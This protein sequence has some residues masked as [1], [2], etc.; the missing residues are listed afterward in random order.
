MNDLKARIKNTRSAQKG[1]TLI[2][3]IVVLALMAILLSI[4]IFG[5]L[6]W[7]DWV[8]FQQEDTA[9]EDIFYAAQNQL[10]E[11]DSSGAMKRKVMDVLWDSEG[12]NYIDDYILA[13][14]T[15]E[16]HLTK[17]FEGFKKTSGEIYSWDSIWIDGNRAR[18]KRTVIHL[19]VQE[20]KYDEYLKLSTSTTED[21]P[22]VADIDTAGILLFDLIAPYISDKSVLNGA[23]SLEFSPE[24]GQV[25]AVCYSDRTGK[26]AY[27]DTT[28]SA[29]NIK[30][31]TLQEREKYMIGYYGVDTLTN[32]I[33]GRATE[34]DEYRLEIENSTALTLILH[35]KEG[36]TQT[37][38][39]ANLTFSIS[40]A[41][42][43]KDAAGYR[44]VMKFTFNSDSI[45]NSAVS[46]QTAAESPVT[47][48]TVEL[49]DGLYLNKGPQKF[50]IPMW[51]D[52]GNIYIALDAADVQAQSLQHAEMFDILGSNENDVAAAKAAFANTYSFYRFGLL[53]TRFI[54]AK[55]T[56][57]MGGREGEGEA[58][59]KVEAGETFEKYSNSG[60]YSGEAVTFANWDEG[61]SDDTFGIRNGRHF[62]NI[63]FE[64]DYSDAF[65]ASGKYTEERNRIFAL[66][67]D[68]DWKDFVEGSNGNCFLDSLETTG[69]TT[70]SYGINL[71]LLQGDERQEL[72]YYDESDEKDKYPRDTAHLPFP[73][74]RILSYGNQFVGDMT[75]IDEEGKRVS[76]IPSIENID[77]TLAANCIY[78]VYGKDIQSK[79]KDHNHADISAQGKAGLLPL[80]LFA[81]SYGTLRDIELDQVTVSGIATYQINK[82]TTFLFTSKVG[83]FV[84][85]N[86][87]TIA[88]LLI[89]VK[90][91]IVSSGSNAPKVKESR[92]RGRADVGGIVGH[93]YYMVDELDS[94]GNSV[95][96]DSKQVISGCE[97]NA[98][99]TGIGY[100]G[101]IIG[102]I[103][104]SGTISGKAAFDIDY[105][106]AGV[107]NNR[108]FADNY[109]A[110]GVSTRYRL[111]D[112]SFFTIDECVNHGEITMDEMFVDHTI[113]TNTLQ[114]GFYYGGITGAALNSYE[115]DR[116][117][118][119][120][121]NFPHNTD[122]SRKVVISNCESYTLYSEDE[123]D[124]ILNPTG[125]EELSE[126]I[127]RMKANFV[128]GIVGGARFA[129]ID[130]CSTTPEK[131]T[132]TETRYS[133][134]F[135]DRY[136]GGVAGY[137]FET[138][139]SGGA[140]Y[141]KKELAKITDNV[142]GYRTD[143][144]IINGTGA[145]GNY[146][147]GG[148]AGAFGRPDGVS[149]NYG[150]EFVREVLER[151][152]GTNS[153]FLKWPIHCGQATES[154]CYDIGLLNTAIVLGQSFDS[155]VNKALYQGKENYISCYGVGGV[156]GLLGNTIANADNIQSEKNK[157]KYLN[158]MGFGEV[159][160]VSGT[161]DNLTVEALQEK[162]DS[163]LFATD[164]V[165]GIVGAAYGTGDINKKN[166]NTQFDS[167][168]DAVVL[169]RNR[170]GG[171]VGDTSSNRDGQS[172]LANLIPKKIGTGSSGMY[173]LGKDCVGGIVGVF[174]DNGGD[175]SSPGINE[176]GQWKDIALTDYHVLGYRGVGGFIG[177]YYG[178]TTSY[179]D[180]MIKLKISSN[181][182]VKGSM[183][184]GGVVGIQERISTETD[185]CKFKMWLEGITVE[186]DCFAGGVIGATYSKD[187]WPL[188]RLADS[189]SWIKKMIITAK[190]G[191]ALVTGLYAPDNDASNDAN[192]GNTRS[193]LYNKTAWNDNENYFPERSSDGTF[194]SKNGIYNHR[195]TDL[196]YEVTENDLNEYVNKLYLKFDGSANPISMNM[197]VFSNTVQVGSDRER[198]TITA[199]IYAACAFGF[200]PKYTPV[201]VA[202][203]R[204][205]AKVNTT[206]AIKA[207]EIGE[208][209]DN[210]YSYLGVVTGRVPRGMIVDMAWNTSSSKEGIYYSAKGSFIGG[211]AEV[212]AGTIQN[213][214]MEYK[215]KKYSLRAT[216][217]YEVSFGKDGERKVGGIAGLNGTEKETGYIINCTNPIAVKG[218]MVGGIA[219]AAGG[220]ST[221]KGCVNHG[222]LYATRKN[223]V[224]GAAGILY[225]VDPLV[226]VLRSV[227][228]E[229]SVNT[230][231]VKVG[232]IYD[233]D[234][235]AGIAY[236]T[237]GMGVLTACRNYAAGL[238]YAINPAEAK[239]VQYC[240]DASDSTEKAVEKNDNYALD[241]KN[242]TNKANLYIGRKNI[243]GEGLGTPTRTDLFLANQYYSKDHQER[244][245]DGWGWSLFDAPMR[246]DCTVVGEKNNIDKLVLSSTVGSDLD[247]KQASVWPAFS[248]DSAGNKTNLTFEIQAVNARGYTAN[249]Y[250]DIDSFSVCWDNHY[251]TDI[252]NF[253]ALADILL[254]SQKSS[255]MDY[256]SFIGAD[257][258]NAI[259]QSFRDIARS[260][261]QK[262]PLRSQ[263]WGNAS[264]DWCDRYGLSV[265]LYMIQNND[266]ANWDSNTKTTNFIQ[267]LNALISD[268]PMQD[269]NDSNDTFYREARTCN[270]QIKNSI[271]FSDYVTPIDISYLDLAIK[272]LNFG[273][274]EDEDTYHRADYLAYNAYYEN[275]NGYDANRDSFL[276][277]NENLD[278]QGKPSDRNMKV[279]TYIYATYKKMLQ[280]ENLP[281]EYD[282]RLE[283]YKKLLSE[284]VARYGYRNYYQYIDNSPFQLRYNIA[285]RDVNGKEMSTGWISTNIAASEYYKVQT[286][287]IEDFKTVSWEK[288]GDNY[289]CQNYT[290][291]AQGGFNNSI[292]LYRQDGFDYDRISSIELVICE[293]YAQH[294]DH[295]IGVRALSWTTNGTDDSM[296]YADAERVDLYVNAVDIDSTI[297]VLDEYGIPL[298]KLYFEKESEDAPDLHLYNYSTGINQ[299]NINRGISESDSS[300]KRLVDN[301]EGDDPQYFDY[302]VVD[303]KTL[304]YMKDRT[305]ING[306]N[307][308]YDI[309]VPR[310]RFYNEV[311]AKY[312]KLIHSVY[313]PN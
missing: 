203:F 8:R 139:Y 30:D 16:E 138:N 153:V 113:D 149:E 20:N 126:T 115:I 292:K 187:Y 281:S 282:A 10:T 230:G 51:K 214:W 245:P 141:T 185:T 142:T 99:V 272:I 255:D 192:N 147:V 240:L 220:N 299:I 219:A 270:G 303:N 89:D 59:R 7:M 248:T 68:L 211:I 95:S 122:A 80:G 152:Y 39:N 21:E 38:S 63:R 294:N 284:N 133:F 179:K 55:V 269:Y 105:S 198:S 41:Y 186:A 237:R 66:K 305:N 210:L 125:T 156:A 154:S 233:T 36:T 296:N 295:N 146:A 11:L 78:G 235:A 65:Y 76:V 279:Y 124:H 54:R 137:S 23:I 183:Y 47:V 287:S 90:K 207:K 32:K 64:S 228:I 2:E 274:S 9:A 134:V 6:G 202:N 264:D 101:G 176:E 42:N 178:R 37:F 208:E 285:F 102:R 100:V 148:I 304:G 166:N 43:Y 283:R 275:Y 15:D 311:D 60:K 297:R 298:S 17:A 193:V 123:L 151:S 40:G 1:F 94:E 226:S 308:T 167:Y 70:A 313:Q 307:K 172:K 253:N 128:G 201:T 246:Y 112:I 238:K 104:P 83:G 182:F 74:F 174:S 28:P 81:E 271:H 98:K 22:V 231:L 26:F 251:K 110:P 159:S 277:C 140:E 24:A 135:G 309:N 155:E 197:D 111:K 119:N 52:A 79:I 143:Y 261:C 5:A 216:Q 234:Y 212:N 58:G 266:Y 247:H 82:Q 262:D 196:K 267:L 144:S 106:I 130:N 116:A 56:V 173:V 72:V 118:D 258:E 293:E 117:A 188:D 244:K 280:D 241:S 18:E 312:L 265:Y 50:R 96:S 57:K 121:K 62:Y 114:R 221:I 224:G 191:A 181:V 93:Q 46:L 209:D 260:E 195:L 171:G 249:M 222:D 71:S 273:S 48:T 27:D 225:G 160:S 127:Y 278:W 229:N 45:P 259:H 242:T 67:R 164:G 257:D 161:L 223:N 217:T 165:G 306:T 87:G 84:G 205:R 227:S 103:Y 168:I 310:V 254:D 218:M 268:H 35:P 14:G 88:N 243:N 158:L 302:S 170:V 301:P 194:K 132:G 252:T 31:R 200:V 19:T 239:T 190:V 73:G 129:Y 175:N 263:I 150:K 300:F 232:G 290:K 289:F 163:S 157:K 107:I 33:K 12:N 91:P 180:K 29:V 85:E 4:T 162:L 108:S 13:Q 215:N 53:N 49:Y 97:N 184:V 109:I 136:V 286:I 61:D 75:K 131:G 199:D 288:Y 86:F 213:A 44:E 120:G 25:F 145:F 177:T 34:T 250:S 236:N 256:Q 276:K 92:I 206:E 77:I 3:L 69:Y 169:G 291:L 189:N 204:N